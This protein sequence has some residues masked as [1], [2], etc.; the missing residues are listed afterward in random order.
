MEVLQKITLYDL[1]GY[2][3]PGTVLVIGAGACMLGETEDMSLYGD[4]AGY[5]SAGIILLG[6]ILGI[7]ISEMSE[8][9]G[10]FIKK[11]TWFQKKKRAG[12]LDKEVVADALEKAGVLKNK[13]DA[14]SS[15]KLNS[16]STYMYSEIQADSNYSRIHNYASAGLTCR[17]MALVALLLTIVWC[18]NLETHKICTGFAGIFLAW[19]FLRRWRKQCWKKEEYTVNWFVQKHIKSVV[20]QDNKQEKEVRE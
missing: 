6:Y 9:L 11:T 3:V 16:Y 13:S 18:M 17:N 15:E 20:G 12:N 7:A 1:L 10:S 2:A 4:Y 19:M 5:I 8:F 14:L